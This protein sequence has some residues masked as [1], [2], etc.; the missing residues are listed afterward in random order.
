MKCPLENVSFTLCINLAGHWP[1]KSK[2]SMNSQLQNKREPLPRSHLRRTNEP[3]LANHCGQY[4][5]QRRTSLRTFTLPQSTVRKAAP[6]VPPLA[7]CP[8]LPAAGHNRTQ[9]VESV[10]IGKKEVLHGQG[11]IEFATKSFLSEQCLHSGWSSL[12]PVRGKENDLTEHAFTLLHIFL[13]KSTKTGCT[14]A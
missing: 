1:P 8:L 5:T 12:H 4:K 13:M 14:T 7:S 3:T 10:Q 11:G 6:P 9:A 2:E